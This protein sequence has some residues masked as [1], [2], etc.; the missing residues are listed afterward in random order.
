MDHLLSTNRNVYM[1]NLLSTNR[2][3]YMDNL[4]STNRN[5][6]IYVSTRELQILM[7]GG[8][9][10]TKLRHRHSTIFIRSTI[11]Y[12]KPSTSLKMTMMA[13]SFRIEST[14]RGHHVFKDI[15]TPCNSERLAVLPEEGPTKG[16]DIVGHVPLEIS[17]TCWFFLR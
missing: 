7:P 15:W 16:A 13:A 8:T 5:V 12:Q 17:G 6:Y 3:V 14:V 9:K 10:G 4:L 11:V 1:D 2:N